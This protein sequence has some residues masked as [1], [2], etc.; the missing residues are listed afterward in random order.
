MV[1][2]SFGICKGC[3]TTQ[4]TNR[5]KSIVV[6]ASGVARIL[7]QGAR[8]PKFVVTKLVIKFFATACHSNSNQCFN[9]RDRPISTNKNGCKILRAS[10]SR[11]HV[12]QFP[13]AWRRHWSKQMGVKILPTVVTQWRALAGNRTYATSS[14]HLLGQVSACSLTAVNITQM[15]SACN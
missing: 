13:R 12:P 9:I 14:S 10:N 6:E 15:L 3:L 8:V 5:T 1:S 7:L 2:I 4:H 11:G